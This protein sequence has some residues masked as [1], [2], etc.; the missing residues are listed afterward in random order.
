MKKFL[1][2]IVIGL[3][4]LTTFPAS[5]KSWDPRSGVDHGGRQ[6]SGGYSQYHNNYGNRYYGNRHYHYNG[7]SNTTEKVVLAALLTGII[8]DAAHRS[9]DKQP[10]VVYV[11]GYPQPANTCVIREFYDHLGRVISTQRTCY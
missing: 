10:N 7:N 8:V 4:V 2:G 1:I 3:A 5:A 6:H 9:K 11:S